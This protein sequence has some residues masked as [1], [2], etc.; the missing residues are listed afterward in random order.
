V[1]DDARKKILARRAKFVA[2][3]VAGIAVACG[4]EPA[5]Q[6]CL[7][8]TPVDDASVPPQPCLSPPQPCLS[9]YYPPEDAAPPRPCLKPMA[10]SDAGKKCDPPYTIDANGMKHFKPECL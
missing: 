1:S 5:P 4:K 6:P 10:P 3:A 2:A 9:V 7:S 8:A